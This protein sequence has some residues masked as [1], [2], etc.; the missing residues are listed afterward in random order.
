MESSPRTEGVSH[1]G[2]A[3]LMYS[4]SDNS[5]TQSYSYQRIFAADLPIGPS[6]VLSYWIY[7]QQ[8]T[9]TFV[10]VDLQ[11]SDGSALRDSGAVDQFGVRAHPQL[12]GEGGHLVLNQWNL[13]RVNLGALAGRTVTRVDVGFD[14]P[15]GTG[16]F[17]GYV[18]D[19]A[20]TDEGGAYPGTNLTRGATVT[21]SAACAATEAPA[22]LSTA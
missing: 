22:R 20:V 8:A 2:A 10:A 11:F 3:A 15:T 12:Q 17:R 21:G 7:P 14:R 13:I 1:S 5:A 4:G 16:P 19:I 9:G 18:D 6:S